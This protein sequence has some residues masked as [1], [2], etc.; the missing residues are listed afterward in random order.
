MKHKDPLKE[1]FG[2]VAHVFRKAT[3]QKGK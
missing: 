3:D 2:Q 1:A